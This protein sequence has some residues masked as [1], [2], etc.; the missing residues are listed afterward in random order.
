MSRISEVGEE[1]FAGLI[2][3]GHE[4]WARRWS[5]ADCVV[6]NG[7]AVDVAAGCARNF[8]MEFFT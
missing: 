1:E 4:K 3:D 8:S 7:E 6:V 5:G 2:W